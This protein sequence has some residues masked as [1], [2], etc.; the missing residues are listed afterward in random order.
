VRE[1]DKDRFLA[2]LFAPAE[3]RGALMALYAFNVEVGRI[4]ELV[5][6]PLAAAVRLQWWRDVIAGERTEE[7]QAHPVAAAL[8]RTIEARGLP[9]ASFDALL[10]A[11]LF[12]A[13]VEAMET[14]EQLESYAL[15]TSSALFALA[16]R[17]VDPEGAPAL[18]PLTRAGGIAYAYA[19]L[20]RALPLHAARRKLY[21]PAEVLQRHGARAE[22][23]FAGR[24]TAEL[25]A[26]LAELR[27]QARNHLARFDQLVPQVSG[28]AVPAVLPIVLVRP[29]LER[30]E[31]RD[32]EPLRPGEIPQWRRQW[33]LWRAAR[34][35]GRRP[36]A[37]G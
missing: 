28:F 10:E 19:G 7:A 22:D 20:M 2:S 35:L 5:H 6:Q 17:V 26:A 25:R 13:A 3:R 33:I 30:M 36:A 21:L 27:T 16:G 18:D 11:R 12:D 32:Y 24:V 37:D 8:V 15:D 23:V 34:R 14:L 1:A 31:R 29:L 9:F 4:A